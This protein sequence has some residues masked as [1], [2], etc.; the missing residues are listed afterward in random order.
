MIVC[1]HLNNSAEEHDLSS[2][3]KVCCFL[4][5]VVAI[6]PGTYRCVVIPVDSAEGK[7]FLNLLVHRLEGHDEPGQPGIHV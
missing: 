1:E 3:A 5:A 2:T 7:V 6:V 4:L